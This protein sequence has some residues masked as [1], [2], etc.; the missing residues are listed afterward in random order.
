[1]DPLDTF[2]RFNFGHDEAFDEKVDTIATIEVS[3]AV[4]ERES[5]LSL[6]G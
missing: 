4:N 2:D 3:A 6:D 5:F 1:M